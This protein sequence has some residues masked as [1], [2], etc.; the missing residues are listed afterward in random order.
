[1]AS[2]V[3]TQ[4]TAYSYSSLTIWVS[5]LRTVIPPCMKGVICC[6]DSFFTVCCTNRAVSITFYLISGRTLLR[7]GLNCVIH[8]FLSCLVCAQ[9]V[10]RHL[11]LTTILITTFDLLCSIAATHVQW[12]C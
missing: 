10:L 3:L 12:M 8:T 9:H 5:A 1:M 11:L 6:L 4:T 7:I 2:S